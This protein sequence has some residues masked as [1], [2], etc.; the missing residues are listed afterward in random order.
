MANEYTLNQDGSITIKGED[1]KSIKFVKE[2]DLGAVKVA[3][4]EKE[5]E[6]SKLQANITDLTT[7][8]ET[9]HQEVLKERAVK[10]QLEVDAKEAGTFK[11]KVA[12]LETQLADLSKVSGETATKLTERLRNQLKTMYKIPDDK[13]SGK[14]LA[15]LETIESTLQMTGL[16]TQPANYD[17]KGG[18]QGGGE[19]LRGKSPLALATMGYE[20]KGKSK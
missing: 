18:A 14:T 20:E 2:S 6:I 19:D 4:K 5:G 3:L 13:L 7:K 9:E 10:E 8:Y 12:A 11:E 1:G 17:G 15:D 16:V